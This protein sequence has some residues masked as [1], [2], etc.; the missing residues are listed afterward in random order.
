MSSTAV[1]GHL[2]VPSGRWSWARRCAQALALAGLS[3]FVLHAATGAGGPDVV[4]DEWI[5]NGLLVLAAGA[6]LARAAAMPE[7]RRPWL[8]LGLGLAAWTA[9]DLHYAI[10]FSASEEPPFPSL[11]DAFYLAFY[12]ASFSALVLLLRTRMPRHVRSLW[13]DG[14]TAALAAAA[15]GASVLFELVSAEAEGSA[16]AI[17]TNLAY[18][19]GDLV[20]LA[21][22]IGVFASTGWRPGAAWTLIGAG[23]IAAAVA[24]GIYLGQIAADAY[25]EGGVTDALWPAAM[26]LLAQAAWRQSGGAQREVVLEGRRVLVTPA[27]CGL[28]GVGLLAYDHFHQTNLLALG[29]SIAT[30]LA[31]LVRLDLTFAEKRSL[32]NRVRQQA[33]TDPVTGL[34]NRRKLMADLS[35]VLPALDDRVALLMIFDL[36]GFKRYNDTFGHPAGDALLGRLGHRLA[37]AV[38]THGGTA[39]RLGGDEFCALAELDE[40]AASA[41]IDAA[42]GALTVH[43]DGFE[44]ASS[45]GAVFLPEEADEASE[46]LRLADQRLYADKARRTSDRGHPQ[47]VL[48]RV[49]FEREPH[50]HEHVRRVGALAEA[51]GRLLG[52]AGAELEELR[53]AAKLYDVGKLAI[54]DELLRKAAP[55][56]ADEWAFVRTHTVIGQRILMAS[57]ALVG[58]GRIVRSTHERWDGGGY[59]DALQAEEIPL[60]ARIIVACDAYVTMTNARPYTHGA[61]P[62]VA[63]RELRRCA[64]AEFDPVV[65]EAVCAATL[66]VSESAAA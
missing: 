35:R 45:F 11:G 14:G 1:H 31:V 18:P 3:A 66:D 48:L 54:P 17:A 49:L 16:A 6:C 46:A 2:S 60:S 41:M 63:R 9:G 5:Y 64:G 15:I 42:A 10:A 58:V 22:V 8:L 23:L 44:V 7:E 55:L 61:D 62:E 56:D 39:Y 37:A 20:L 52:A 36:D 57:P 59:P 32:L 30:L 51:T 13:L 12:P 43:G 40:G 25:A 38:E 65:V 27:V 34:G 29:L 33:M 28:I 24:D 50:L 53:L 47:D 26:L 19:L 21:L 4:Y